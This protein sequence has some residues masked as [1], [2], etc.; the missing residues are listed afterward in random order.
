MKLFLKIFSVFFLLWLFFSGGM[1]NSRENNINSRESG[2]LNEL[3]FLSNEEKANEGKCI[4]DKGK[5]HI[6]L[7]LIRDIDKYSAFAKY[8]NGENHTIPPF[9]EKRITHE[10]E[11]VSIMRTPANTVTVSLIKTNDEQPSKEEKRCVRS[12]FNSK[13]TPKHTTD[14]NGMNI[15]YGQNYFFVFYEKNSDESY[16]IFIDRVGDSAAT[17]EKEVETLA[18]RFCIGSKKSETNTLGSVTSYTLKKS[19]GEHLYLEMFEDG[20]SAFICYRKNR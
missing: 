16:D 8:T 3:I 19:T 12:F 18:A 11:L 4:S 14:A 17:Q 1:F 20:N 10:R 13:I 9:A 2:Y 7:S 15:C 6:Q 5:Q